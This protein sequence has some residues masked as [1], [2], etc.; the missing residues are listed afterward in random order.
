M[1]P[2]NSAR[3]DLN[4]YLGEFQGEVQC[5]IWNLKYILKQNQLQQKQVHSHVTKFIKAW[6]VG[7]IGEVGNVNDDTILLG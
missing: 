5:Q 1:K 6:R 4:L 7:L 2:I 3:L